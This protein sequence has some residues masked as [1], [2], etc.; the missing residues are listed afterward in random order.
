[1]TDEGY[2]W[3]LASAL[4]AP[5][6][7]PSIRNAERRDH[8]DRHVERS[9]RSVG[10]EDVPVP[11]LLSTAPGTEVRPQSGLKGGSSAPPTTDPAKPLPGR[12]VDPGAVNSCVAPR[13]AC[14][15]NVSL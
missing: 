12:I 2:S 7:N 15:C 3:T 11:A 5:R 6:A 13:M 1:M 8:R 4:C 10:R 14:G 9:V